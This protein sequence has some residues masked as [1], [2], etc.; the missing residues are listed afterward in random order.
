MQG[1]TVRPR[2]TRPQ[3]AR[4]LKLHVFELDPKIFAMNEFTECVICIWTIFESGC[5]IQISE[6]TPTKFSMLFKHNF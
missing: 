6:A 4:T 5:G 1:V 3:A 2:N